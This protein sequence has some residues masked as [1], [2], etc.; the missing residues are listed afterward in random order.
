MS[1]I[2]QNIPAIGGLASQI[3]QYASLLAVAKE[4]GKEVIF[5]ESMKKNGVGFQFSKILD[6]PLR[7]EPDEFFSDFVK[8]EHNSY[9][10]LDKS[11]FSLDPNLNYNMNSRFDLFHYWYPKY[12]DII[13]SWKWNSVYLENATKRLLNLKENG[14]QLVSLHVRRG[15]YLLP[16]HNHY[17][18][19]GLDY[20]N[21]AIQYFI[22]EIEKYHFVVFSNDIDWCKENL[23]EG[24][25]VTFLE[26][27]AADYGWSA[28]SETGIEDLILMS[29]CDHNI[30]G[31]SSY[32]WWAAFKNE[33]KNKVVIC[34]KNYVRDFSSF[35]HIN[36]NYYPNEWITIDNYSR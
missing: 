8:F 20:Y 12:K 18:I 13:L 26:P 25:M 2:T 23:I 30:I 9:V 19:L 24:D 31:N 28:P 21:E 15:D 7:F 16:K 32:S 36:G 4:N 6:I 1:F 27:D 17:C 22:Q 34:P 11:C 29:L 33:N 35:R 5:A 3:Q 10:T 14:K